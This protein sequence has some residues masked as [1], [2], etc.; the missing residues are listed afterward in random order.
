MKNITANNTADN[1]QIETHPSEK[2]RR[3]FGF[4]RTVCSCEECVNNCRYIPGYLIPAD[5]ERIAR[6]LGVRNTVTFAIENLLASPGAT[7]MKEGRLFQIPTLVP[8]RKDD[9]SCLF[10]DK[11]NLCRFTKSLLSV[12]HFSIHI[13]RVKRKM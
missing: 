4:D 11:N 7:V 10:L 13:S 12:V 9:G 3:E 8:R 5:L 1:Q 2:T 6:F